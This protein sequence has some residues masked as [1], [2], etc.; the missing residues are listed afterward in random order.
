M[1]GPR[2]WWGEGSWSRL[3]PSRKLSKRL[4]VVCFRLHKENLRHWWVAG[5]EQCC[6]RSCCRRGCCRWWWAWWFA[7]G[8]WDGW[9]EG[10][11]WSERWERGWRWEERC[12]AW[13]FGRCHRLGLCDGSHHLFWRWTHP[14][15]AGHVDGLLTFIHVVP[16][17]SIRK[18]GAAY[19][20]AGSCLGCRQRRLNC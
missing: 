15:H 12:C 10:G 7:E 5:R 11:N 13:M 4:W 9:R 2:W 20:S 17:W 1:N 14:V 16:P 18:L 8:R 3:G 19:G 6:W